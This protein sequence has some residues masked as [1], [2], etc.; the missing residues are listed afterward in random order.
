VVPLLAYSAWQIW[1]RRGQAFTAPVG[2]LPDP[3]PALADAL[4]AHPPQAK[5]RN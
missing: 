1:T 2:E 3:R 4:G 5:T